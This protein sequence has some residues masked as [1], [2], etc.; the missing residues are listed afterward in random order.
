MVEGQRERR[1]KE[2]R[3]ATG[4]GSNRLATAAA[5]PG[6][7]GRSVVGPDMRRAFFLFLQI[8]DGVRIFPI[9]ND[10]DTAFYHRSSVR[11]PFNWLAQRMNGKMALRFLGYS[12]PNSFL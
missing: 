3:H 6:G 2:A 1:E 12:F 4:P 5:L 11:S 10:D 7:S 9:L 8:T